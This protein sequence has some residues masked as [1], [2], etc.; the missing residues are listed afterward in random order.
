MGPCCTFG[1]QA[2]GASVLATLRNPST[3]VCASPSRETAGADEPV[4]VALN[5][6]CF[7]GGAVDATFR[8]LPPL[9]PNGSF[10]SSGAITG[11]AA[12]RVLGAGMLDV[13][14][15]CLFGDVEV[16]ATRLP[17]E[18]SEA[19]G[20]ARRGSEAEPAR[21]L[22]V[23]AGYAAANLTS[24]LG[25]VAPSAQRAGATALLVRNFD[26]AFDEWGQSSD[27]ADASHAAAL[28]KR[29]V[30]SEA[31][32]PGA[33]NNLEPFCVEEP[34]TPGEVRMSGDG[35]E[36]RGDALVAGGTLELCRAM[37]NFTGGSQGTLVIG[38]KLSAPRAIVRSFELAFEFQACAQA[39]PLTHRPPPRQSQPPTP[40]QASVHP[41][42]HHPRSRH[43]TFPSATAL[44]PAGRRRLPAEQ[45]RRLLLRLRTDARGRRA[46]RYSRH[47]PRP[48]RVYAHRSLGPQLWHACTRRG[49]DAEDA[50]LARGRGAL[51]VHGMCTACARHV[52]GMCALLT[53]C[54]HNRT[55][56][57]TGY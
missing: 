15:R 38:R 10:P 5:G 35:D 9:V 49:E 33:Y 7:E 11:G 24:V 29:R 25:C 57:C 8:F 45:E 14:A 40:L 43:L 20:H 53:H 36:L 13:D 34:P 2:T 37:T 28:A 55:C 19:E 48:Q 44:A 52:H 21:T 47:A 1:L 16:A 51:H 56:M 27:M 22:A 30:C 41:P 26:H 4:T 23:H 17:L 32:E 31:L 12:V 50:R 42:H 46:L 54:M 3:L 39:P 6:Q 18:R